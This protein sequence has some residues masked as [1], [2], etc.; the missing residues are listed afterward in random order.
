[1]TLSQEV[2]DG[3]EEAG[4][5]CASCMRMRCGQPVFEAVV[6]H[7]EVGFAAT[8][9]CIHLWYGLAFG[10]E[11]GAK[12]AGGFGANA[13]GESGPAGSRGGFDDGEGS[14]THNLAAKLP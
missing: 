14:R 13:G 7:H 5:A 6:M 3:T 12:N 2:S 8:C 9:G 1:M 11:I 10:G 4:N